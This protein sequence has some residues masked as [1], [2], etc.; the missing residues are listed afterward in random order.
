MAIQLKEAVEYS[1]ICTATDMWTDKIRHL[2]YVG[3]T[4]RYSKMEEDGNLVMTTKA[5]SLKV[6]DAEEEKNADSSDY[7]HLSRVRFI[8]QFR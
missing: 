6:M 7:G 1:K 3:A 8:H 2:K 5:L 4:V